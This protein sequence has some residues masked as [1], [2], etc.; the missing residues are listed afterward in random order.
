MRSNAPALLP[1]FRSQAQAE[2]L[3]WLYLH[4]DQAFSLTDLARR[5]GVSLPTI[6]R[7]AERLVA[8]SL[9]TETILGRNRML[10]ANLKHPAAEKLAGLLEVSFGP[11]HVV[12]QEF[13]QLQGAD[14][15]LIFGSW[16]A[17]YHGE[18]G[19]A[20][21]DVDVMVIGD[22]VD[23]GDMYAA[24]DRAQQR[25]GVPVNPVMRTHEQWQDPSDRL[26]AQ[27]HTRPLVDVMF[28]R[29]GETDGAL[30]T[31]GSND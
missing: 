17:R 14:Q 7:E 1:I 11:Q 26:S 12:A 2:V 27:L 28:G 24:S 9:V 30:E 10:G 3:T 16:A 15:V 29:L 31:R 4:P 23:R 21:R 13:G 25:L 6:H 8:S 19:H 18:S 5:V 20:P 22:S